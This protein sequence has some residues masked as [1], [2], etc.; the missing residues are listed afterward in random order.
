MT[1]ILSKIKTIFGPDLSHPKIQ[2]AIHY[3]DNKKLAQIGN[4]VLDLCNSITLYD[5]GFFASQID[6]SRQLN[7]SRDNHREIVNADKAFVDYMIKH[8]YIENNQR[9]IG[10]DRSDNYLEGIIGA[11]YLKDG[12]KG[13]VSFIAEIYH[14]RAENMSAVPSLKD[15][16]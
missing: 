11:I 10:K 13:V 4:D 2:E 1:E 9:K 7:F 14:L 15:T 16:E 12:L 6:D 8:D 5:E 3:P